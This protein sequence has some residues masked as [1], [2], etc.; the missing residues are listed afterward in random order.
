VWNVDAAR[1]PDAGVN[2]VDEDCFVGLCGASSGLSGCV[3][4]SGS[5]FTGELDKRTYLVLSM[6]G[7]GARRGLLGMGLF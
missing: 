7:G 5:G 4:S 6:S 1:K 2:V 3:I